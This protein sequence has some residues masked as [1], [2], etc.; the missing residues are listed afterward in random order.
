MFMQYIATTRNRSQSFGR[1][2]RRAVSLVLGLGNRL[3]ALSFWLWA[4][5]FWLWLWAASL[6]FRSRTPAPQARNSL[7][8]RVTLGE[9]NK[10]DEPPRRGPQ[11]APFLRVL[12]G[13]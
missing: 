11:H 2:K 12:G 5:G 6:V 9:W 1:Q 7:A 8:Q 4:L 10:D 3:L 13:G